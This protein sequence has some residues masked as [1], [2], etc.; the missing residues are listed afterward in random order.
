M[1]IKMKATRIFVLL[2]ACLFSLSVQAATINKIIVFGDSLS[3]NGNIYALTNYAIPKNPPY[4]QGRFSNGPVWIESLA[5]NMGINVEN[6]DQFSVYAY[7]GA[8]GADESPR[9]EMALVNLAW[10]VSEYIG[11]EASHGIP[12]QTLI[13]IWIGSNDYLSGRYDTD[14]EKST[15]ATVSSIQNNIE[16]LI[17]NGAKHFLIVNLSDLGTTPKAYAQGA[18]FAAR[19]S[20]LSR[21]HNQKLAAMLAKLRMQHPDVQLLGF[22]LIPH[23]NDLLLHPEKY[24]LINL[25]DACY[26]GDYGSLDGTENKTYQLCSNPNEYIYWDFVHPSKTIH[27]NLANIIQ[28]FLK[29]NKIEVRV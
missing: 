18:Q 1:T 7:A 27:D 4:F 11:V 12:S 9:D 5:R 16:Y 22:D 8:W 14:P 17:Q 28:T 2:C 20:L 3:D 26:D 24:H 10:E 23:F 19:L 25:K 13:T 21:L 29:E 6:K 15:S